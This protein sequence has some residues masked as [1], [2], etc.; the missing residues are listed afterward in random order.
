[1]KFDNVDSRRLMTPTIT[2]PMSRVTEPYMDGMS[3]IFNFVP[4][5]MF[6]SAK[7]CT[8][9]AELPDLGRCPSRLC[10][11]EMTSAV[12]SAKTGYHKVDVDTEFSTVCVLT[13]L[14]T[15]HSPVPLKFLDRS[16]ENLSHLSSLNIL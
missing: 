6:L 13:W 10:S 7:L 4:R 5:Y 2:G 8:V 1:M 16:L 11:S 3:A 9:T 12:S 14:A 15:D